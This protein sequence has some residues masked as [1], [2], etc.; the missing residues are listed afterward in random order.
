M[1][2][3]REGGVEEGLERDGRLLS[4]LVVRDVD[5]LAGVMES[6]ALGVQRSKYLGDL[7]VG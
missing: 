1:E 2:G 4:E 7:R 6:E 5:R 3:L